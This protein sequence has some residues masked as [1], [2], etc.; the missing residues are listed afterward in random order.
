M[1]FRLGSSRD[2]I[3]SEGNI[4]KKHGFLKVERRPLEQG[5]NAEAVDENTIAIDSSI[6]EGS[7]AYNK[8]YL[9]EKVHAD[10]MRENVIDYGDDYIRDGDN[11]YERKG[12]DD[13]KDVVVF[14]G[15][16]VEVGDP[17]LPW[18]RRAIAAEKHA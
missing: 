4:N 5:V 13:G 7:E 2:S 14:N 18:E 6:P 16:E 12:S 17:S 15:K 11:E 9:H 8:A 1:A 3:A 10:E